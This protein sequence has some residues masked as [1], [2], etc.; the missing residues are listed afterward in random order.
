MTGK[1]AAEYLTE[2]DV[3]KELR[4]RVDEAGSQ[5]AFANSRNIS[6]RMLSDALT[7]RRSPLPEA[8][9]VAAG[10]VPVRRYIPHNR[11]KKGVQT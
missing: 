4:R 8:I 1:P 5:R 7:G 3:L 11:G 6:E 9:A 10:Y 2:A